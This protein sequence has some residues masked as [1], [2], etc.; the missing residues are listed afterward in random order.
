MMCRPSLLFWQSLFFWCR[1]MLSPRESSFPHSGHGTF[2]FVCVSLWRV[3]SFKD[4]KRIGQSAHWYFLL[5]VRMWCGREL[6]LLLP[7]VGQACRGLPVSEI[8]CW[9]WTDEARLVSSVW[10]PDCGVA[11]L[12]WLDTEE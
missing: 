7:H 6:K 5:C 9:P 3:R 10:K 4:A 1:L 8:S 11:V 2:I 12:H